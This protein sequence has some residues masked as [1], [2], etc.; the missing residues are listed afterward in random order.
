MDLNLLGENLQKVRETFFLPL[1]CPPVQEGTEI[2][3]LFKTDIVSQ[4]GAVDVWV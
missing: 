2:V 3:L 4:G 1:E